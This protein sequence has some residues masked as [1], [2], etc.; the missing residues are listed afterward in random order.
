[1]LKSPPKSFPKVQRWVSRWEC[2][3]RPPV[4]K[5][6]ESFL[7]R[8]I[9]TNSVPRF[10]YW[11]R[12]CNDVGAL[13]Q[14]QVSQTTSQQRGTARRDAAM[15]R[16]QFLCRISYSSSVARNQSQRRR[17]VFFAVRLNDSLV[18]LQA[19]WLNYF[20]LVGLWQWVNVDI[21]LKYTQFSQVICSIRTDCTDFPDCLQILVSISVFKLSC[22]FTF[23]FLVSCGRLS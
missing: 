23:Q 20:G 15:R 4:S 11:E 7:L 22:F 9:P 21:R 16:R 12:A 18:N 1:M 6:Q 14:W 5:K 2:S 13:S 17:R 10:N 8:F 3:L 19:N